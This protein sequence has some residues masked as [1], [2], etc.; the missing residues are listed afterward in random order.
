[1]G[2]RLYK[3]IVSQGCSSCPSERRQE[4]ATRKRVRIAINATSPKTP[5]FT[6]SLTVIIRNLRHTL[7]SRARFCRAIATHLIHKAGFTRKTA[8]TGAVTLIQ[9][10]GSA[11]IFEY[12]FSNAV[13][14]WVM[15]TSMAPRV[16]AVGSIGSMNPPVAN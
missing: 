12:S 14:G 10:F 6:G 4:A 8:D 16:Q 13:S 3:T 5:C 2:A 11:L 9:L 7:Q 1:M 15:S